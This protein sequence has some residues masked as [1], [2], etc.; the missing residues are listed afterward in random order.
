MAKNVDRD[1]LKTLTPL[2]GLKPENQAEIASKTPEI[3]RAHV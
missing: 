2:N 1:F 3:G